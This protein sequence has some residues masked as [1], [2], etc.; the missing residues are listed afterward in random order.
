M[1][2]TSDEQV[3]VCH[4]KSNEN[5]LGLLLPRTRDVLSSGSKTSFPKA[6]DSAE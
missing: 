5:R 6:H 2:R 3:T 1:A 4:T